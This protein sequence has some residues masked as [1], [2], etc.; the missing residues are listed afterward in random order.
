MRKIN[1]CKRL[2]QI[3]REISGLSQEGKIGK[4][5]YNELDKTVSE[6][7]KGERS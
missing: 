3:R 1:V 2:N 5:Y 6:Y 7:E 4:S